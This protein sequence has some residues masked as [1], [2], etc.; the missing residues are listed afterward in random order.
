M[1]DSLSPGLLER[2][3]E[4]P[5]K[6][7][8][9]RPAR[10][11]DFICATP[12]FR[13][14]RAALPLAEISIIALPIL[15]DLAVRMPDFNRYLAFPGFPGIAEQFFDARR[16]LN[17]FQA[18]QA[19][20]FDLA[21]QMYGSGVYSNPFTLML[22]AQATAGF[23]HD[24]GWSSRLD[25]ALPMPSAGHEVARILAL[26]EFLG[27]KPQGTWTEFPLLPE[28]H[29]AA[30]DLLEGAKPPL[31]GLHPGAREASRQWEPQRLGAVGR[32]LHR[33]YGGS[34]VL[35]GAEGERSVAEAV[36]D[37]TGEPCIN[38]AGKTSL[39]TLGA[40]IARLSVLVANSS[41]P[42]HIAYALGTSTVTVFGNASVERYGPPAGNRHR[43]LGGRQDP[44]GSPSA[45]RLEEISVVQVLAAAEEVMALEDV[46]GE[47]KVGG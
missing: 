16:A 37:S 32:A 26:A 25:A 11:G 30:A 42:A 41:G 39:A 3:P 18:M 12:A 23:V 22:G 14:L 31:I 40:V 34:L 2:L 6:V 13:A 7:V 43:Y 4:S 45:T 38:L 10:L 46:I 44:E 36:A 19:E 33:R 8:L 20:K 24:P 9:V 47:E 15:H 5:R 35:L 1:V 27:A 29:A 28:D 21:V 17:F